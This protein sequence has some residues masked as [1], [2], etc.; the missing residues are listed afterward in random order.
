MLHNNRNEDKV[1][2]DLFQEAGAVIHGG[3]MRSEKEGVK[4]AA[5]VALQ[6]ILGTREPCKRTAITGLNLGV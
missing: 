3:K 1:E 4:L 2:T 5:V 6:K